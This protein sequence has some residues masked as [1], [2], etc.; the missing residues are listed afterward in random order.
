MSPNIYHSPIQICRIQSENSGKYRTS[1]PPDKL[2]KRQGEKKT[3]KTTLTKEVTLID[4][5]GEERSERGECE[6]EENNGGSEEDE[7]GEEGNE[8]DQ[9]KEEGEEG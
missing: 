8:K 9:E 4:D 6:E 5:D 7:I 3:E 2:E 1:N